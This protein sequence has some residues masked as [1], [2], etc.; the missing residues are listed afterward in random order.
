MLAL[1]FGLPGPRTWC[2]SPPD[3]TLRVPGLA[4]SPSWGLRHRDAA[5]GAWAV[6]SSPSPRGL[7]PTGPPAPCRR[8]GRV[9]G[10]SSEPLP[11]PPA[12]VPMSPTKVWMR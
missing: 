12:L 4:P 7:T 10:T 11:P 3:P 6:L 5:A 1:N 8:P 2:V 9:L